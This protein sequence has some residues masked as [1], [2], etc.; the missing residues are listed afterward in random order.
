MTELPSVSCSVASLPKRSP[1]ND[2]LLLITVAAENRVWSCWDCLGMDDMWTSTDEV[3]SAWLWKGSYNEIQSLAE[4]GLQL[5]TWLTC[6][7]LQRLS[8]RWHKQKSQRDSFPAGL[9]Q[10]GCKQIILVCL[11]CLWLFLFM[12][13]AD[14]SPPFLSNQLEGTH[15]A[16]SDL[17]GTF[18]SWNKWWL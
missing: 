9:E 14:L 1:Q 10:Q 7:G 3:F 6:L 16:P 11:R 12:E 13:R 8:W 15:Q 2:L 17:H 18:A 5:K 4:I